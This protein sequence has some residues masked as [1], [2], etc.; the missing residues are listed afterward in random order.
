[1]NQTNQ[2]FEW[3]VQIGFPNKHTLSKDLNDLIRRAKG[4]KILILQDCISLEPDFLEKIQDI[5]VPTTFPVIKEGHKDW[6]CFV[7]GEIEPFRWEADLAVSPT[8][9]FFDVGGFDETF[10]EGWSWDNVEIAWRAKSAGYK[11]Y[12]NSQLVGNAIDHDKEILHPFRN[13][14]KPNDW[15]ANETMRQAE[16]GKY[17]LNYL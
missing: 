15:R 12:C 17:K 8:K 1:M 3:L 5:D 16:I 4:D 2:E 14:L 9:M 6:R 13:T 10:D 11:F 7:D